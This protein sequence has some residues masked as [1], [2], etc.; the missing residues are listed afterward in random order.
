MRASGL[1]VARSLSL[2]LLGALLACSGGP[3]AP[4]LEPRAAAPDEPPSAGAQA[5]SVVAVD[6]PRGFAVDGD[7]AEWGALPPPKPTAPLG[8]A[9][10]AYAE[11]RGATAKV[12]G[13]PN[14]EDAPSKLAVALSKDALLLAAD[15][16][17]AAAKGFWIA[18][19]GWVPDV[20]LLGQPAGR[21]GFLPLQCE[22]QVECYEAGESGGS[23]CGVGEKPNPPE[24]VA[25]CK[26]LVA[27]HEAL[28]IEHAQRFAVAFRVE[29]SGVLAVL[30]GGA[31]KP[32]AGAKVAFKNGAKGATAEVSIPLFDLPRFGE[33]PLVGLRLRA[34]AKL[35]DATPD[36]PAA[37]WI[38]VDLPAPVTFEPFASLRA[39]VFSDQMA[40][41]ERYASPVSTLYLQPKALSYHPSDPL[42]FECM[43]GTGEDGDFS[44]SL[45]SLYE[46][47]ATLGDVEVGL[48][49]KCDSNSHLVFSKAGKSTGALDLAGKLA[50][51]L[52]RGGE[53]HVLASRDGWSPSW[54]GWA[55]GADG[56]PRE[57]VEKLT[58]AADQPDPKDPGAYWHDVTVFSS[59]E[60]DSFGW[61]GEKGKHAVE[62]T[63][64]WDE[65]KKMYVG[66]ERRLPPKAKGRPT[67]K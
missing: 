46:K 55:A 27:H 15:L 22:N 2:S 18:V 57:V 36:R 34:G 53:L 39:T 33:A 38:G 32:V 3:A 66:K 14:P 47:R 10:R 8:P 48:V 61:R 44:S 60:L 41:D 26:K 21:A 40:F 12:T 45:H 20:P 9:E 23:A 24:V 5:F 54:S 29:A 64:R 63:W 37:E 30:R 16:G 67:K 13:A 58:L 43:P 52:T 1:G 31:T 17:P 59:K 6:A 62:V 65:R 49:D 28:E 35:G 19:G 56:K 42:H 25:S 7:L 11:S 4:P 51:V 50:G